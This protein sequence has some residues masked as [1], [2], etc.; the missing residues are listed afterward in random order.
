MPGGSGE[1][2]SFGA[3]VYEPDVTARVEWVYSGADPDAERVVLAHDLGAMEDAA[4]E[5][6]YPERTVW[7]VLVSQDG[8]GVR[9]QMWRLK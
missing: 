7:R 1:A 8:L 6:Y 2:F 9:Y 3:D 5:A 4:I